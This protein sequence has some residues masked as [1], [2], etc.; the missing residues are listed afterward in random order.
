MRHRF[1]WTIL[2]VRGLL[3][4][5]DAAPNRD[6]ERYVEAIAKINAAHV[7][8]PRQTKEAELAKK[9]PRTVVVG[10]ARLLKEKPSPDT[11]AALLQC[12]E[13]ALDLA[14]MDHFRRVRS[15]LL[16]TAPA[17]AAELGDAV[18][19]D[20]FLVRGLGEFEKGYLEDFARI[21]DAILDAYQEVFGFRE[22]SKVPGKKI[23]LRV[24]LVEKITRPPHF[25]PQFP[26]HSEIDMPVINPT[27]LRSPTPQGQMMFY[28]L[29]HELG[30]LIAM[31]GDR[32]HME[33]HHAWAHYT[34]VAIVEH[35]AKNEKYREVL[36]N[37][38][39]VRWRSLS[40]ERKKAK[41]REPSTKNRE[42]VMSLLLRLHDTVGAEAIGAALNLMDEENKGHR[43]NHVRY[44]GFDDF[45]RAL[46]KNAKDS[47]TNRS[48]E[49]IFSSS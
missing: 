30:H 8:N 20:R 9:I 14:E 24:R 48:I 38:R 37:L 11:A 32:R 34:G 41:D 19:R 26:Y 10:L 43:I 16:E 46:K 23:R 33:D 36:A 22:W 40:L 13:A 1:F 15:R 27:G 5:V 35:M 31:W 17:S 6:A 4:P 29:C 3:L 7:K 47:E 28:G 39:D 44:Y 12:G 2:L 49:E 42:G 25:A 21:T 18:A 45:E